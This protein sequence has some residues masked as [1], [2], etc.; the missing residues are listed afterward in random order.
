[1]RLSLKLSL[2]NECETYA[3]SCPFANRD[4]MLTLYSLIAFAHIYNFFSVYL[5]NYNFYC[6]NV[7]A[8][9]K[10]MFQV[11]DYTYTQQQKNS[12]VLYIVI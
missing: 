5:S 6:T 10:V 12:I 2:P 3:H 8:Y 4:A 11:C 1:M 7:G 9:R